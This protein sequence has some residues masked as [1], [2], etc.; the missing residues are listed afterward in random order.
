MRHT[1]QARV[2]WPRDRFE[3]FGHMTEL[4][5][6]IDWTQDPLGQRSWRYHLHTLGFLQV[7]IGVDRERESPE[8]VAKALAI[9]LDWIGANPR[10]GRGVSDFAWYDM[11]VGLRAPLAAVVLRNAACRGVLTEDD[12]ITVLR[13]L[14]EHGAALADN[15]KYAHGHNHGLFQD[16]GLLSLC[17]QLP[18]L[19][20]AQRWTALALERLEATL[21]ATVSFADATHLEHSPAYHFVIVNILGRLAERGLLN[22]DLSELAERMRRAARWLVLPDGTLPPVGDTPPAR[23]VPAWAKW[24]DRPSGMAVMPAAGFAVVRS[25]ES[26]LLLSCGYHSQAHKQADD[27]SFVLVDRGETVVTDPGVFAYDEKHPDRV[28]ARSSLAHN[29]L[30]VDGE[31][32]TWRGCPAYGSALDAWGTRADWYAVEAHNPLLE[33]VGVV[34]RRRLVYSPARMLVILDAVTAQEPHSY[35]RRFTVAPGIEVEKHARGVALS[36]VGG[37]SA[38]LTDFSAVPVDVRVERGWVFPAE[39]T[40]EATTVVELTA[41]RGSSFATVIS[42]RP[43]LSI[44]GVAWDGDVARLDVVDGKSMTTLWCERRGHWLAIDPA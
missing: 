27:L 33:P 6:P 39:R 37:L 19:E 38:T 28:Y 22:E 7:L 12:A 21:R 16:E 29:V 32:F 40:R 34:H 26:Y 42:L 18:F 43:E 36:S 3:V 41:P 13:S 44:G 31:E 1:D 2:E 10:D 30:L 5:P 20:E 15:T 35:S 9:I 17:A 23:P 11:A 4:R 25:S 8:A 14:S 24:G